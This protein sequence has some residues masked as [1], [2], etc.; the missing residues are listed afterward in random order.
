MKNVVLNDTQLQPA[1]LTH[2]N[3]IFGPGQPSPSFERTAK[4]SSLDRK[5]KGGSYIYV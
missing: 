3:A 5:L 4:H 2:A 1:A